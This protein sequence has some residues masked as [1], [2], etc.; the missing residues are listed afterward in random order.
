MC[1]LWVVTTLSEKLWFSTSISF[2]LR[3][4]NV[5]RSM[6]SIISSIALS[7]LEIVGSLA[8]G[9]SSSSESVSS[10]SGALFAVFFFFFAGTLPPS[11]L[12]FRTAALSFHT[13]CSSSDNALHFCPNIF[14]SSVIFFSGLSAVTFGRIDAVNNMYA[15]GVRFFFPL[16][17]F[18][19][20]FVFLFL[21]VFPDGTAFETASLS[22]LVRKSTKVSMSSLFLKPIISRQ[23][24]NCFG[25]KISTRLFKAGN[26][27]S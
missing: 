6:L 16:L 5:A 15:P 11:A 19:L 25:F 27:D 21:L 1:F 26:S 4:V 23:Y 14:A 3:T 22:G 13:C 10:S 12:A 2:I 8:R 18:D 24:F 20:L 7:S 17:D 9:S